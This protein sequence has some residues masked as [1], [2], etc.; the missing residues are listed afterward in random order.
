MGIQFVDPNQFD[1]ANSNGTSQPFGSSNVQ[2]VDPSQFDAP[3]L[4]AV[5][6]TM[7]GFLR[8]TASLF[9]GTF[10][11]INRA[12]S[13]IE[14]D[15]VKN[16]DQSVLG[17]QS[18]SL[19]KGIKNAFDTA[20][21]I[22]NVTE[23]G[24]NT[25][26]GKIGEYIP[27]LISG[28]EEGNLLKE[29]FTKL[30]SSPEDALKALG[31]F[32]A[33]AGA[34]GAGAYYGNEMGGPVGEAVGTLAGAA[35]PRVLQEAANAVVTP[36][37]RD[38]ALLQAFKSSGQDSL[39]ALHSLQTQGVI[40]PDVLESKT[41]FGDIN[42]SL[43]SQKDNVTSQISQNLDGSSLTVKDL[44]PSRSSLSLDTDKV[45]E[46]AA[47]SALKEAQE[48]L[49]KKALISLY[50]EQADNVEG[51]FSDWQDLWKKAQA[52]DTKA[53]TQYKALTDKILNTPISGNDIWKIRQ[54]YD[55]K[56]NWN[57]PEFKNKA[58]IFAQ[59]RDDLA[60]KINTLGGNGTSDLFGNLSNLLGAEGST[61]NLADLET[62][63]KTLTL[64]LGKQIAK[65]PK[66][67]VGAL[68]SG[69]EPSIRPETLLRMALSE[70]LKNSLARG[71]AGLPETSLGLTP[72]LGLM[73]ADNIFNYEMPS[74]NQG[75]GSTLSPG[76]SQ[77]GANIA[78][79]VLGLS[80]TQSQGQESYNGSPI[81]LSY[82]ASDSYGNKLNSPE[83]SISNGGDQNDSNS[84]NMDS[85]FSIPA[86]YL[87]KK[88]VS[89]MG[90]R[91]GQPSSLEDV[92]SKIKSDPLMYAIALTEN[93]KM[94]PNAKNPNSSATG[95]FQLTR[96]TAK[97]LGV[98]DPTDPLQNY[99]GMV[100]LMKQYEPVAE[101]DPVLTYAAHVLGVPTLEKIKN[102]EDL[103]DKEQQNVDY[104]REQ[105]LPHFVKNYEKV[106]G[107]TNI[108]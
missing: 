34:T 53:A 65:A 72:G 61:Q 74:T 95:L 71:I 16:I 80:P 33:K 60:N 21:G 70:G 8:G 40:T 58:P 79:K 11:L 103:T 25:L 57:N 42:S 39:D 105:A 19:E 63:G 5:G 87:S 96:Q 4:G 56:I 37:T 97:N 89:L 98:K 51:M 75:T 18:P 92:I 12:A 100:E 45:S 10:D 76:Q 77:M 88:N 48:N 43:A 69:V 31:L 2:F 68:V 91:M 93:G 67:V 59:L 64:P 84:E 78:Q 27:A 38:Q 29:G 7:A 99:N 54:F 85:S 32:G 102:G 107:E 86:S 44:F 66:S 26:P 104:F 55:S 101:R 24:K 14:P 17:T 62:A 30:L 73:D 82:N 47:S 13:Y 81:S 36:L 41:P 35:M 20:T 15:Y 22:Q 28:E 3:D 49:I 6:N 52:G 46:T 94:D 83:F 108:V 9:G 23:S 1:S 90:N 106:T 50:P